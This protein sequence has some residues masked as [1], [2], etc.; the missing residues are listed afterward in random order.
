MFEFILLHNNINQM[1][2]CVNCDS[3]KE[4]LDFFNISKD[5][6]T[7]LSEKILNRQI[8]KNPNVSESNFYTLFDIDHSI[9]HINKFPCPTKYILSR[10]SAVTLNEYNK[11]LFNAIKIYSEMIGL[12]LSCEDSTDHD[13]SNSVVNELF[14][15][16]VNIAIEL[17]FNILFK[18]DLAQKKEM[19][20]HYFNMIDNYHK[21]LVDRD[22]QNYETVGL[23]LQLIWHSEFGKQY[24]LKVDDWLN[25]TSTR[26]TQDIFKKYINSLTTVLTRIPDTQTI[27]MDVMTDP[28]MQ[29][30][31]R[32]VYNE[33]NEESVNATI[34]AII[35]NIKDH[36]FNNFFITKY[37]C[38]E[39][40]IENRNI[41]FNIHNSSDIISALL[42]NYEALINQILEDHL[43]DKLPLNLSKSELEKYNTHIPKFREYIDILNKIKDNQIIKVPSDF[44]SNNDIQ[45][46]YKINMIDDTRSDRLLHIQPTTRQYGGTAFYCDSTH[47][48]NVDDNPSSIKKSSGEALLKFGPNCCVKEYIKKDVP[49]YDDLKQVLEPYVHV[50]EPENE[51]CYQEYERLKKVYDLKLNLTT[52]YICH[53][54]YFEIPYFEM[55][56]ASK[57]L[58]SIIR[59]RRNKRNIISECIDSSLYKIALLSQYMSHNDIK[60]NNIMIV[61]ISNDEIIIF[62]ID[63]GMSQWIDKYLS[64]GYNKYKYKYI[65]YKNKYAILKK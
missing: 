50:R 47:V 51:S 38:N 60:M 15:K 8:P 61:S 23:N 12:L 39:W 20:K 16:H 55:M 64:G 41:H 29:K 25:T 27:N 52:P 32:G 4:P 2:N 58:E 34:I 56:R 14:D 46:T 10:G 42:R 26:E 24:L 30:Y 6:S 5:R 48:C 62:I 31:V 49:E 36:I 7:I 11:E 35:F 53:H 18:L 65:K 19:I 37:N 28:I 13:S 54:C 63:F 44:L 57:T 17:Q 9:F 33:Y 21:R 45:T 3:P 59:C 40:Y 43:I 1:G 22:G